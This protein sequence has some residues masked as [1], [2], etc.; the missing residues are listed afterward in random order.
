MTSWGT[1]R[2]MALV[3]SL[4]TLR[5]VQAQPP[6]LGRRS[7]N[8]GAFAVE[9]A[10]ELMKLL[11]ETMPKAPDCMT[12]YTRQSVTQAQLSA[13]GLPVD[14]NYTEYPELALDYGLFAG[15]WF[16]ACEIIDGPEGYANACTLKPAYD[17]WAYLDQYR[18]GLRAFLPAGIYAW[19]D[20]ESVERTPA[21]YGPLTAAV[22]AL[23][24]TVV[25]PSMSDY[26]KARALH[27]YAAD[28]IEYD[29]AQ[30]R[31]DSVVNYLSGYGYP[32]NLNRALLDGKGVCAAYAG[33]YT[34]LCNLFGLRCVDTVGTA[35]GD[36]HAWNVVE[37]DDRWYQVDVTW[38]DKGSSI[39][40]KYFLVSDA[41]LAKDHHWTLPY[42][43]CPEDYA[44]NH[45]ALPARPPRAAGGRASPPGADRRPRSRVGPRTPGPPTPSTRT[46]QGPT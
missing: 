2:E 44:A 23:D 38:D 35:G 16:M 25:T 19:S 26:E 27:D 32:S 45:T 43:V 40:Y 14:N 10:A 11:K 36:S 37:V 7:A 5:A 18:R 4:R 17:S 46:S 39:S 21:D 31:A 30:L 41:S 20:P 9:D 15:S 22:A 24:G 28:L 6:L 1:P 3:L 13:L 34:A 33:T 29:Y 12:F 8:G 42:P